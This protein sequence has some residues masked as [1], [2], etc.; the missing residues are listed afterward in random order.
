MKNISFAL[1]TQQFRDRT[2][3]VTRRL[4]W[5]DLRAGDVLMGCKKCMGLAK[6]ETIERLGKI[7]VLSVECEPL[8][9]I[10]N[11]HGETAKEGF[12]EMTEC[13]F[14][15]MFTREMR[16]RTTDIITRIEFEYL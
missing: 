14:I 16:C 7:R 9:A 3:T 5:R 11:Y 6:G 8:I 4:G 10:C 1:T 15:D 12:P 2:K 13:Q